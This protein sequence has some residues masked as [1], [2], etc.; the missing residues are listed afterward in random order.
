[1]NS[2]AKRLLVVLLA[3][4]LVIIAWTGGHWLWHQ[5]LVMHGLAR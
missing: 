3:A 5:L 2:S 4:V 1:M